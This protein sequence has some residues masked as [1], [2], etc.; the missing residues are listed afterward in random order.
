[1]VFIEGLNRKKRTPFLS[2]Q[3]IPA[4]AHTIFVIA[5]YTKAPITMVVIAGYTVSSALHDRHCLRKVRST[6]GFQSR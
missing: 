1:M 5:G 4:A 2:S 3:L 6:S